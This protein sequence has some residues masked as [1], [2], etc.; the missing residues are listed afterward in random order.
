MRLLFVLYL[1]HMAWSSVMLS[2]LRLGHFDPLPISRAHIL[3]VFV[4]PGV[5]S[6]LLGFGIGR[7]LTAG[8]EARA[9]RLTYGAIRGD[10]ARDVRLTLDEWSV[11]WGAPPALA[12]GAEP[13]TISPFVGSPVVLYRPY[14]V[15]AGAS[16]GQVAA[17]LSLAAEAVYGRS[18]P[19]EELAAR[20]LVVDDTGRVALRAEGMTLLEDYP[21][22]EP[23]DRGAVSLVMALLVAV[24]LCLG[25]PLF[26]RAMRWTLRRAEVKA[27]TIGSTVW[28]IVAAVGLIVAG[29]AGLFDV[30]A[31]SALL[32]I[33]AHRLG[34]SSFGA[35][36]G[37]WAAVVV[38]L[39]VGFEL[40]RREY[41]RIEAPPIRSRRKVFLEEVGLE[42]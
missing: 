14:H 29:E 31:V 19:P 22:L 1:V 2:A 34:E 35:R 38:L 40:G 17:Q 11:S 10:D 37:L 18:I 21:G 8:A 16:L 15:D 26:L 24:P 23:S 5:L 27:F 9:E 28:M 13:P 42:G 4:A 7:A 39:L 25:L 20:Y 30:A 32:E 6:A 33:S 3:A 41:E 36:L 12:N